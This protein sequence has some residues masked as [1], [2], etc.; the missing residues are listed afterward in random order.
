M[1]RIAVDL[2]N[3]CSHDPQLRIVGTDVDIEMLHVVRRALPP[4]LGMVGRVV[5]IADGGPFSILRSSGSVEVKTVEPYASSIEHLPCVIFAKG[6]GGVGVVEIQVSGRPIVPCKNSSSFV[7]PFL[8]YLRAKPKYS[9]LRWSSHLFAGMG[10]RLR[11]MYA[12]H[13]ST[14]LVP[15]MSAVPA[16]S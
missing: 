7:Q 2:G 11:R 3:K 15:V 8:S 10:Y 16:P 9:Q 6:L 5:H 1:I 14:F 12:A 4:I 13:I